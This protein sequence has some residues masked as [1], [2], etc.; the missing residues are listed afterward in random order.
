MR[1]PRLR[2]PRPAAVG[3]SPPQWLVSRCCGRRCRAGPQIQRR[4]RQVEQRRLARLR[5]FPSCAAQPSASCRPAGSRPV[6]A[7]PWLWRPG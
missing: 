2:L 7:R 6:P 1:R 4:L 3:G 5:P